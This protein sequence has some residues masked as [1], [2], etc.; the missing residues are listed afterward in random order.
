VLQDSFVEM[1]PK[2]MVPM[3]RFVSMMLQLLLMALAWI[4]MV[5]CSDTGSLTKTE[6]KVMATIPQELI[7]PQEHGTTPLVILSLV[8]GDMTIS[9]NKEHG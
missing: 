9:L 3:N 2:M 4:K 5:T 7:Q 6:Q 8:L 1:Y